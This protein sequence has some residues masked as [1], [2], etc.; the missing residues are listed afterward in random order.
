MQRKIVEPGI[1]AP[2][3]ES[4]KQMIDMAFHFRYTTIFV[5]HGLIRCV[6][7]TESNDQVDILFRIDVDVGSPG[8]I[9]KA[10]RGAYS[11]KRK[12]ISRGFRALLSLKPTNLQALRATPHLHGFEM[13]RITPQVS[14]YMDR[15]QARLLASRNDVTIDIPLPPFMSN[16][17]SFHQLYV[18]LKKMYA[19][20]V[21]F[22]LSSDARVPGKLW[23]PRMK[24]GL[25]LLM[26]VPKELA[27]VP[28]YSYPHRL[29]Q[30]LRSNST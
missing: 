3:C 16:R 7:E 11:L 25:M 8:E 9:K 21:P 1:R 19:Y 6:E 20:D 14:R 2:N 18:T 30:N 24:V 26:D 22:V 4:L 28:V 17:R 23:S 15:S 27:L 12:V 29:L 5:D 13:V 10:V